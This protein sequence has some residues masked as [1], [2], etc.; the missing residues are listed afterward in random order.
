MR[1]YVL[2]GR[3]VRRIVAAGTLIAA[4][5]PVGGAIAAPG[6][7]T[8]AV[9]PGSMPRGPINTCFWRDPV[10][11]PGPI[12]QLR[13]ENNFAGP[14]TDTPYYYTRFQLPTGA[15]V[16]LHGQYPHARFM[17]Y[18]TY[19]TISGVS[20]YPATALIDTQIKPDRGSVNPFQPG[21][22]R[23]ASKRS[24]T[25]TISGAVPPAYGGAR[26]T[27]Y[28]GQAGM[29]GQ[30]QQV[31]V[32]LR[33]YRPDRGYNGPGGVALPTPTLT[34]A[35]GASTSGNAAC[36]SLHTEAGAAKLAK[37]LLASEGVPPATYKALRDAAPAPHPAA[38][39]IHWYRF[40][41]T[42]RLLEPFY[43]GTSHANLIASLPS[44]L[45]GGFYSTPNNAYIYA[46]ADR[47]IGPNH[48]GH[49]I[50]VLHA[51]MPTH[52]RTYNRE[53]KNRSAGTQTRFWSLCNYGSYANPPLL[54]ANSACLFDER[55]PTNAA[56]DY[57]MV[58]SLPQDR[59]KNATD[60][61]GVAWMNWGTA[62]DGQGRATLDNLVIREQLDS[63]SYAQGIDKI[64]TPDTEQRVMGAHYPKGT[65]MTKTQFQQRGC[66]A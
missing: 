31:E 47:T 61:C 4:A 58:V 21:A 27:L 66:R 62:G 37:T 14:S 8:P 48:Q 56:G 34:L 64:T 46:Y 16:T 54:P 57:T 20:G 63:R 6:G 22:R 43:A 15:R 26:N 60:K 51:K 65:Y 49:N 1:T 28:A 18:T 40:F 25:V 53:T 59:P 41:N 52:P 7:G 2:S 55:V 44:T 39:P 11:N 30:T 29:T 50:L 45:T 19:K 10:I 13:Q 5:A 23:D 42:Q 36:T 9:S 38:N 17:S 12:D 33:L 35:N 24:Y 3:A 32:V